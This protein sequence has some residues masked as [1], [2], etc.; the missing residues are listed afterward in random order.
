MRQD[1]DGKGEGGLH[2]GEA[3]AVNRPGS[4]RT[5]AASAF[6]A[7]SGAERGDAVIRAVNAVLDANKV[8]VATAA[9][10]AAMDPCDPRTAAHEGAA[11]PAEGASW[12]AIS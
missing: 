7:V 2:D 12:Q 4:Q 1:A 3:A 10:N 11:P 9:V 8:D 5:A 6:D